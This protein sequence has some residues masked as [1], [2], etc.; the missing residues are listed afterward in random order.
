[1]TIR[2]M[3]LAD[4]GKDI[5]LKRIKAIAKGSMKPVSKTCWNYVGLFLKDNPEVKGKILLYTSPGP[6]PHTVAHAVLLD[7]SGE[8]L[9][10]SL[11][12]ERIENDKKYVRKGHEDEPYVLL[13]EQKWPF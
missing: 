13:A 12:G 2:R 9:M 10:D 5:I 3:V 7:S 6:G 4:V 1:M 8:T 11:H